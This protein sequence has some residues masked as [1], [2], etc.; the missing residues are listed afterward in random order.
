MVTSIIKGVQRDFLGADFYYGVGCCTSSLTV[1]H[2]LESG[3]RLFVSGGQRGPHPSAKKTAGG[4]GK[5][6]SKSWEVPS[7]AQM[8]SAPNSV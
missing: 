7:F 5:L 6:D 1:A 4:E 2:K 8:R 3:R